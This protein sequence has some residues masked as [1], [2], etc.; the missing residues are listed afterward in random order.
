MAAVWMQ[1]RNISADEFATNHPA[2]ELGKKLT[3]IVG[4]LMV[5]VDR[6]QPVEGSA[7]LLEV[8]EQLT[9]FGIG[10]VWVRDKQSARA[11]D[12]LITDGDLRRALRSNPTNSW[13]QFWISMRPGS[14]NLPSHCWATPATFRNTRFKLRCARQT[15]VASLAATAEM[16][17]V[18]PAPRKAGAAWPWTKTPGWQRVPVPGV[19]LTPP[20]PGARAPGAPENAADAQRPSPLRSSLAHR[21]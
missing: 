10:A 16:P 21:R 5:P 6:V 19:P 1:R 13:S 15:P 9:A 12:G 11:I 20:A 17:P 3:M 8:I 2:G 18:T 14:K 4:D 7:M